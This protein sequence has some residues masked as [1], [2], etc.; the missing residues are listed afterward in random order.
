MVDSL[1]EQVAHFQGETARVRCFLHILNLVVRVLLAQFGSKKGDGADTLTDAL[2]TMMQGLEVEGSDS[3]DEDEDELDGAGED[4]DGPDDDEKLEDNVLDDEVESFV[5]EIRDLT[6]EERAELREAIVPLRE[7]L[8]KV[9]ATHHFTPL[10]TQKLVPQ[11]RKLSNAILNSS[12]KLLPAWKRL[13][14]TLGLAIRVMPRDVATRWNSTYIML[15]F[16]YKYRD[17]ID[18]FTASRENGLRDL[19]LSKEEWG[20]VK[21]LRSVLKVRLHDLRYGAF[22]RAYDFNADDLCSPPCSMSIYPL[23]DIGSPPTRAP[24]LPYY[25]S[26]CDLSLYILS[27]S[28]IS[29]RSFKT[30]LSCSRARGS[31][32]SPT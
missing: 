5:Q 6:E 31:S 14:K 32:A 29:S 15:E 7:L 20:L 13:L 23:V 4:E 22:A 27:R 1:A 17:A 12:T 26:C 19:E 11:L 24:Y 28:R 16:A 21:E 18:K 3:E 25:L 10:P 9:S 8:K 30:Q 2:E